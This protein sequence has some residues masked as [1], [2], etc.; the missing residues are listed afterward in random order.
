MDKFS[1]LMEIEGYEDELEFLQDCT[2]DSINP[3][4][5]MN[6]EC[7]YTTTVEPDQRE[8]WCENCETNTVQAALV[9]KGII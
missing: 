3:G 1:Q 2:M 4:I 9:I 5:C 6:K 8:G 7:D